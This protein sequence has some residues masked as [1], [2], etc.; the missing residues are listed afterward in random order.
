MAPNILF[1]ME[2]GTVHFTVQAVMEF[3]NGKGPY[4]QRMLCLQ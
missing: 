3:L 4:I 2:F 1:D